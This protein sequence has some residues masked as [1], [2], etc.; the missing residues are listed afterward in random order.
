MSKHFSI[1]QTAAQWDAAKDSL[2]YPNVSLIDTTGD[3]HYCT[4]NGQE[5]ANAPFGSIIMGE[6]ST[7]TLF[8]I[9][10][11]EYNLT[12]Y[13]LESYKPIAVCIYD[14][15]SNANNQAVFMAVQW[16]DYT[17][18][19][20]PKAKSKATRWGF[21]GVDLSQTVTGIRS[22]NSANHISSIGINNAMKELVT[23]DYSGTSI[24]D[25]Y[26]NGQSPAFCSCWRF[27]TVGTSEG[28]WYLPSYYDMLKYK[29]NNSTI[30]NVLTN[31]KTVAGS[32]YL[33]NVTDF[34]WISN[35]TNKSNATY[36]NNMYYSTGKTNSY[37]IRPVFIARLEEV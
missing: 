32:N 13:P 18:L 20:T 7:D 8:Y 31:I 28:D 22:Q 6:V 16:A 3:L 1:F 15:A 10:N 4:Y 26:G 25:N 11:S 35:E 33:N 5:V 14:K 36:F 21:S 19:G 30:N 34:I 12:D 9:D 17:A 24:S 29:E 37:S 23:E 27:K 2:D